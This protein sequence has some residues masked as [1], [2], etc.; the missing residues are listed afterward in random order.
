MPKVLR[1]NKGAEEGIKELLKFLLENGDIRGALT[2][3]KLDESSGVA[4]SLVTDPKMLEDALPLF[5]LMPA[6]A[7]K[8]LS[9]ITLIEPAD[10]PIAV[11][12]RPCELRAFCRT[13]E[14]EPGELRKLL[15]HKSNLRRSLSSKN[16]CQ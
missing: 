11:I 12:M 14:A 2:L 3:T 1:L 6:N 8:V 5:P 10:K 9:R 7:G 4:Y 13:L 15:I 16:S